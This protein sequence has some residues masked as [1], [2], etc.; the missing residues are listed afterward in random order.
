MVG[1]SRP[2]Q[3]AMSLGVEPVPDTRAHRLLSAIDG[4]IDWAPLAARVAPYFAEGGR[5]SID[6]VLMLKM[7]VVGYLFGIPSDRQ[8]VEECADRLSLREFLGL[9]REAKPPSHASFTH[10]RQRLGAEWFREMLHEIVRQCV[11]A[12]VVL[13][14]ARTIDATRVKAQAGRVGPELE[15][16]AAEDVGGYVEAL[17]AAET[18]ELPAEPTRPVNLHDPDAG[19]QTRPGQ[20][21]EFGY[22]ASF[23]VEAETGLITDATATTFEQPA[24]ALDHVC[25]DPYPV[26]EVAADTLYDAGPTLEALQSRGIRT[27][28][29]KASRERPGFLGKEQFVYDPVA[30]SYTCPAGHTLK[31]QK[32][33]RDRG[34]HYYLARATDCAACPLKP[35]CTCAKRRTITRSDGEAGREAAIRDGPRYRHLGQRRQIHEH[36]HHLAKRDHNLR[37]ARGLGLAAMRIQAALTAIAINLGKLL[38]WRAPGPRVALQCRTACLAPATPRFATCRAVRL[39]R[40]LRNVRAATAGP[41]DVCQPYRMRP[42][43]QARA[44]A[45]F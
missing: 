3:Y 12:G 35:Y 9:N 18:P 33:R 6:P 31:H 19:L 16:P 27:Y 34:Q 14:G 30:D 25:H 10:W 21:P 24:T 7:M 22:Q 42:L 39:R 41:S 43:R 36:L 8:L 38:R 40:G 11:A 44:R 5:P 2:R 29:P 1:K 28:V 13:S 37:R 26:T 45:A 17:F 15:V 4:L 20:P 32:Y 23:C